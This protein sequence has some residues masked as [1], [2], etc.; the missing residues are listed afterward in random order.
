MEEPGLSASLDRAEAALDRVERALS[1]LDRDRGR[2]DQ[3]R[4]R[5]RDAVA[6]LD[7]LIRSANG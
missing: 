6:E 2:D 7:Q 1:R 3:L 5:V 4:E